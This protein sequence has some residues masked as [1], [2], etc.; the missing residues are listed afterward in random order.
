MATHGKSVDFA[1]TDSGATS[2]NI[3][4]YVTS[5][6]SVERSNDTHDTTTMG[7][8]GHTFIAGLTN[9]KIVVN[10]LWDKTALTGTYTVFKGLLGKKDPVAFI[11]GPE[12]STAGNVKITGT[13]VVESYV[14]SAPVADLVTAVATLQISGAVTDGTY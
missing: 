11:Y 9:G 4:T 3:S 1:I 2:R 5:V 6:A 12:G 7:N 14:E 13:V 10:V 8:T